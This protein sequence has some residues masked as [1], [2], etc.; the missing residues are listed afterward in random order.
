MFISTRERLFVFIALLASTRCL[1]CLPIIQSN[2]TDFRD[3][4]FSKDKIFDDQ[5]L[6]LTID[7]I[8]YNMIADDVDAGFDVDMYT[9]DY[10]EMVYSDEGVKDHFQMIALPAMFIRYDLNGDGF[11]TAL[12]LSDATGTN[13]EDSA[14]PFRVAD[15]N[16]EMMDY[17]QKVN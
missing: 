14:K 15:V 12:E 4:L 1:L 6:D 7:D 10:L 11:V 16:G 8:N 13:L 2:D 5:D 17:L 9:D 3:D